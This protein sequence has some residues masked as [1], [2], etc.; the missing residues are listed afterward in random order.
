MS[1]RLFIY[2]LMTDQQLQLLKYPIGTFNCPDVITTSDIQSW[3]AI[4]D[5]FPSRLAQMVNPLTDAQLDTSYRPEGWTIRQVIHHVADSHHH[6]Y[7][8]FKWAMTEQNPVIKAYE[9]NAWANQ[10]D[11]NQPIAL[12]ILHIKAVHAKLVYYLKGLTE[13]DLQRTFIHPESGN[14]VSLNQNVGI[15]A[16]HSNHH[17]AHIYELL[18]RK[19]WL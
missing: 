16:W 4:L 5:H 10:H 8:R 11:Y 7:I 13:K 18:K 9:E 1:M 3:I 14:T 2:I 15:Y 17:Y 6:S 19:G 12:S